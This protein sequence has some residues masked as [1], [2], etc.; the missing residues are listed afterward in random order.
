MSQ[1]INP[2]IFGGGDISDFTMN[3]KYNTVHQTYVGGGS[4]TLD[5]TY[6]EVFVPVASCSNGNGIFPSV[7]CDSGTVTKIFSGGSKGAYGLWTWYALYKITNA[8]GKVSISG[9][10]YG[11]GFSVICL[12]EKED[13]G[14]SGTA[15]MT[16][17]VNVPAGNWQWKSTKTGS[18]FPGFSDN[19][20]PIC[21]SRSGS[22]SHGWSENT[23]IGFSGTCSI[24]LNSQN[25]ASA[26]AS[27]GA[28][29]GS[30]N[31]GINMTVQNV[32]FPQYY[33]MDLTATKNA[34]TSGT[35]TVWLEK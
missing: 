14:E 27:K 13:T 8:S 6:P 7:V 25:V 34:I 16:G 12:E 15:S 18:T 33:G 23:Q 31:W 17:F 35:I 1:I 19:V 4:Y 3:S 21:G 24:S 10:G 22:S 11:N 26:T 5:K 29:V 9:G 32:F 20:I 28:N 30:T 2:M